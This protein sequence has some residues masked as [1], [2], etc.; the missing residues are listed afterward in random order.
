ML[1]TLVFGFGN[2]GR[3]DDGLGPAC[4]AALEAL[5]LPG[6]T[7]DSD[8]QLTVEDAATIRDYDVVIFVDAA[9]GGPAPFE[10]TPLSADVPAV[11]VSDGP[12]HRDAPPIPFSS[13]SASPAGVLALAAELFDAR[14]TAYLLGIRGYEFNEF[15]EWLSPAAAANLRAALAFLEST[16]QAGDLAHAAT[17][18]VRGASGAS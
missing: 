11:V 1:R 8:Y 5:A 4:A 12:R 6:V 14:P 17:A 13:H 2:P 15:G 9:L 18:A 3:R 7:I 10:F 16:L